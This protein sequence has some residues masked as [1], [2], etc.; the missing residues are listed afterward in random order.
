[1]L[2]SKVSL[3]NLNEIAFD[4]HIVILASTTMEMKIVEMS[5]TTQ[6]EGLLETS[7]SGIQ[8]EAEA[9]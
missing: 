1:M 9:L 7:Q 5:D 3:I 6:V 2:L 8:F 4:R